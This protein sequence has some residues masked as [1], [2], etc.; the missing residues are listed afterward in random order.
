MNSLWTTYVFPMEGT[1]R[2]LARC[3]LY[4]V[5][6]SAALFLL[7]GGPA[8][9]V[10][11]LVAGIALAAAM[12]GA[13]RFWMNMM[14]GVLREPLS[15]EGFVLRI[16]FLYVACGVCFTAAMLTAKRFG[17][18]GFSDVPV[19]PVFVFGARAGTA[20][21]LLLQVSRA[22]RKRMMGGAGERR[23]HDKD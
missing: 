18:A 5:P 8:S 19:E 2:P 10:A 22:V 6:A 12:W 7:R 3:L 1:A 16:P 20:L 4:A 11:A 17:L 15:A 21:Y 14:R 23:E 13:E 9:G